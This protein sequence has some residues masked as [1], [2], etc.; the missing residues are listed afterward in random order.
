MFLCCY[1]FLLGCPCTNLVGN[2]PERKTLQS[3][4][5]I[6]FRRVAMLKIRSCNL[7]KP[8]KLT[9][10]CANPVLYCYVFLLGCPCTNLV[11]N[12]PERKTLAILQLQNKSW[13][14]S[15]KDVFLCCYV[16]L[17]GCPCT[18]L[19][20]NLPERKTLQS[21]R[22]I[23]RRVDRWERERE[24]LEYRNAFPRIYSIYSQKNR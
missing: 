13:P 16:F 1:V 19:L 23:F 8:P 12:L 4:R 21:S 3:S 2:L 17:L 20:G 6:F 24:M 15:S 11:G 7:A 14:R 10:V 18:N 5:K 9:P 22:K